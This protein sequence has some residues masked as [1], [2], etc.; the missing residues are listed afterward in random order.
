MKMLLGA[1]QFALM[2]LC[3]IFMVVLAVIA[4]NSSSVKSISIKGNLGDDQLRAVRQQLAG[5]RA[6]ADVQAIRQSLEAVNWIS[7]V[8]VARRWPSSLE[9]EVHTARVVAY[10]NDDGFITETGAVLVT[11]LLKF[12]NLPHLYGPADAEFLVMQRFQQLSRSLGDAGHQIELLRLSSQGA[13][14]LETEAG[15][16]LLLGKKDFKPRLDRFLKVSDWADETGVVLARADARYLSGVAI[17]PADANPVPFT[18][19][20]ALGQPDA[21]TIEQEEAK[22]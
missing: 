2:T 4:L 9:V 17:R 22:Q 20:A 5:L 3:M 19:L 12:E 7:H 16:Q 14:T 8:S 1:S 6:G 21:T 15:M 11:D 13:W 18:D 10:W